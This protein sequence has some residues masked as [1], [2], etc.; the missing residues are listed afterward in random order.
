M[1]NVIKDIRKWERIER[2][3]NI[4]LVCSAVFCFAVVSVFIRSFPGP[5][6]YVVFNILSWGGFAVFVALVLFKVYVHYFMLAPL[7][8]FKLTEYYQT[9][10]E[11]PDFDID[12]YIDWK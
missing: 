8:E 11:D 1:D 9:Q 6:G 3:T 7:I 10:V 5:T 2:K 4:G 12:K